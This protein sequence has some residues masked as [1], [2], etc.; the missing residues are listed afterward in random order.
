M[1]IRPIIFEGLSRK[2]TA[3]SFIASTASG[4]SPCPVRSQSEMCCCLLHACQELDS[5][6]AGMRTSETSIQVQGRERLEKA[7]S[8]FEQASLEVGRIE[9]EVQ[10]IPH[11][12]VVVD[13][14]NLSLSAICQLRWMLRARVKRNVAPPAALFS[15]HIRRHGLR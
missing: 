8:G 3:P 1:P 4:T 12:L 5:D 15:A 9:Q 13:N 10:R 11:R 2:S 14:V 6:K 7:Q